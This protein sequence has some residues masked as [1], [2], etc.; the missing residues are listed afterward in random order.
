[1]PQWYSKEEARRVRDNKS[2]FI[3]L[4]Y[5]DPQDN[6]KVGKAEHPGDGLI[7]YRPHEEAQLIE[8]LKANNV[9]SRLRATSAQERRRLKTKYYESLS[10]WNG[11]A[12]HE[13]EYRIAQVFRFTKVFNSGDFVRDLVKE[14]CTGRCKTGKR[15]ECVKS[16][17]RR[18]R[19]DC[20]EVSGAVE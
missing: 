7:V 16:T 4:V 17:Q 5:P 12:T 13:C 10:F 6:Y 19:K 11:V 2:N 20:V 14:V 8:D 1:M 3:C 9:L 15:C 18:V